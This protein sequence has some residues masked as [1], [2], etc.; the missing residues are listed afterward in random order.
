VL[1]AKERALN[2][3]FHDK[4]EIIKVHLGYGTHSDHASAIN[5][6][7]YATKLCL[8]LP[9]GILPPGFVRHIETQIEARFAAVAGAV[10]RDDT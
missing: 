9:N 10:Y 3:H 8:D 4:T 6:S 5:Q 7:V 1:D 2:I